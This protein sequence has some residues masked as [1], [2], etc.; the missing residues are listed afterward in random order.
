VHYNDPND[1]AGYQDRLTEVV[2]ALVAD[3]EKVEHDG[4][5]GRP[6]IWEFS[7]AH[8]RTDPR[9]LSEGVRLT[10]GVVGV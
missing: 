6:R 2:N 9:D 8:R 1:P 4:N 3:P 7:W 10:P 5:A